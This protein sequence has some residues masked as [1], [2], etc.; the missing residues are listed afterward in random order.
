MHE[1]RRVVVTGMGIVSPVGN[2]PGPL[3]DNV[4]AGRSGIRLLPAGERASPVQVAAWI[5]APIADGSKGGAPDRVTQLALAAGRSALT[6]AGL[7]DRPDLLADMG[8]HL[9]TVPLRTR[10]STGCMEKTATVLRR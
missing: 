10:R 8:V 2:W 6:E 4:A 1:P 7:L 3:F 5:D 9:G